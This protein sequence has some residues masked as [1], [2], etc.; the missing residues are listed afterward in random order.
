[1]HENLLL[2]L[3]SIFVIGIFA[4]WLAWRVNIPS[5]LILLIFGFIAGPVS[6]FIQPD[7]LLGELLFP[8]V[9]IAVAVILYEGGLT[10][11]I[12]EMKAVGSV[13]RNMISIG[14]LTTW[15]LSILS[16]YYLLEL[17]LGLA[18][19]F[20]AVLVVTGPT[21]IMP[22]LRYVRP[23]GQLKPILKWEGMLNDPIGALLAVLVFESMLAAGFREIT[24][25]AIA[26]VLKTIFIGGGIGFI[27]GFLMMIM[28]KH[29]QLPEFLQNA[30][31]LTFVIIVFTGSNMIQAESGLFAV[32]IMGIFLANQKSVTVKH[33]I[34]FK[35]NLRVLLIS[36]L[37]IVLAARLDISDLEN[38]GW[39]S[40][41]FL[42]VLILLIRPIAVFLS[43]IGSDLTRNEKLFLAW[44]APRGIVA[45][46]VSS[47][48]ALELS[49]NGFP[50][51]ERLVPLTFLVIVGTISIY[52]L[53]A[54][55]I[56]KWLHISDAAPQGVLIIGAHPLGRAIA[57]AIKQA[58]FKVV[59]VDTNWDNISLARM[60]GLPAH[61]GNVLSEDIA[62]DLDLGG[63]GKLLAMTPNREVNSLA[64]LHFIEAFGKENVFQLPAEEEA[65]TANKDV[66]PQLQG[67]IMFD[68]K[69]GY[70]TLAEHIK[71]ISNLK[72]TALTGEFDYADFISHNENAAV[73]PLF[74][75]TSDNKL[76][77]VTEEDQQT[78]I[79]AG[80]TLIS[81][82]NPQT[83]QHR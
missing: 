3:A 1:M 14:L 60:A 11:K 79:Q 43:T 80:Q 76:V 37:F 31:S 16:A 20:G 6:G 68:G 63:I 78:V 69:S 44:M 51:A 47:L 61:Y 32:T 57:N 21:V 59:L 24:I 36:I 17:S 2:G 64:V 82:L 58:G 7:A 38:L 70:S 29:H 39:R 33:I 5:I 10:L 46:A 56:A 54:S 23:A 42:G 77:I 19:L 34:E 26:G 40:F 55:P 62:D 18:T 4:Q 45:A 25:L 71:D 49:H 22:L 72:T 83:P 8:F 15:I 35:E 75:I 67:N 52:G 13:V 74:L 48:F 41:V 53:S 27:G 9:S 65:D 50:E 81:L 12:K 66:S 73:L 28:L 30:A